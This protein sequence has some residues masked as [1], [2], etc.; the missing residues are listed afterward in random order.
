M[1]TYDHGHVCNRRGARIDIVDATMSTRVFSKCP[2][3]AEIY[4]HPYAVLNSK[5]IKP[6]NGIRNGRIF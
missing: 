3:V 5:N 6:E 4:Q 2:E 1:A